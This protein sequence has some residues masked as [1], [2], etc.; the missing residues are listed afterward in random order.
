[1]VAGSADVRGGKAGAAMGRRARGRA[2]LGFATTTGRLV[3]TPAGLGT[4]LRETAF[5]AGERF[6]AAAFFGGSLE[7]ADG[8]GRV[9][10]LAADFE[11]FAAAV[12]RAGARLAEDLAIVFAG[13]FF[14]AAGRAAALSFFAAGFFLA[15]TLLAAA[16]RFVAALRPMVFLI[17]EAHRQHHQLKLYH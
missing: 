9:T 17:L 11:P 5:L 3:A 12:F 14:A 16:L 4:G 6:A 15:E 13:F 10:R 2:A 7:R 8:A 1:M